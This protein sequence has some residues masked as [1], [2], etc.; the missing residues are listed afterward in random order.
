M[1][2]INSAYIVNAALIAPMLIK[3]PMGVF[4]PCIAGRSL[5]QVLFSV[6]CRTLPVFFSLISTASPTFKSFTWPTFSR[7]RSDARRLVLIPMVN[8]AKSLG[9]FAGNLRSHNPNRGNAFEGLKIAVL[10]PIY[11]KRWGICCRIFTFAW[12]NIN[13]RKP[14]REFRKTGMQ[15]QFNVMYAGLCCIYF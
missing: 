8:S 6:I 3:N 1:L 7:S 14:V 11:G 12:R 4:G 5:M 13:R 9:L 10:G 15:N 2:V